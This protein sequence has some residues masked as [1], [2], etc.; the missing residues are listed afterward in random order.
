[1]IDV[2]D[3]AIVWWWLGLGG[4]GLLLALA[5]YPDTPGPSLAYGDKLGHLAAFAVLGAWFGALR[6]GA[7]LGVG[8]ALLAYG[9]L[10]E[11]LQSLT[12]S[13]RPEWADL[14]ANLVGIVIGIL[15]FSAG[16]RRVLL[17]IER[18]LGDRIRR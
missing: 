14:M 5:L 16:L 1:M 9:G 4:C 7:F 11:V 15:L 8:L 13:R 3:P 18:G 6:R 2:R 10:I 17:R 12:P